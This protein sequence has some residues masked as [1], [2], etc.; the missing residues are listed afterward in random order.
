MAIASLAARQT[1]ADIIK[2][3]QTYALTATALFDGF[4]SCWE[5]KY[6]SQYI[7]PITVIHQQLDE[8]WEP[9]LQTPPFP[10][11]SSGHGVISSSAAT[12]LTFLYGENFAFTD[13]TELEYGMGQRSFTSFNQAAIEASLSR[14][15]G[16]IHYKFTCLASAE[17]GKKVGQQLLARTGLT[18]PEWVT[19]NQ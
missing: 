19:A 13:T 3:A 8:H 11:Y 2:S 10:E 1:N 16:G 18:K 4:I 12:A 17:Q 5:E 6:R 14:L 9:L 7:R 15:Y